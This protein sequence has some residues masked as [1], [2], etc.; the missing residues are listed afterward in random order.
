MS[1]IGKC[2]HCDRTFV[3]E[4]IYNGFNDTAYVYCD[5]CGCVA[6]ISAWSKLPAGVPI[7]FHERIGEEI[8]PFLQPCDCGGHFRASAGPRCPHCTTQLSPEIATGY[9]EA[10]APGAAMGWQWQ[11]SWSG[12]YCIIIEG[13][14]VKAQWITPS[15]PG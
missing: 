12:L 1:N 13:H 4:L 3:Y 15:G 6:F 8:E 5:S 14:S 9:L 10:N 11:G 2:E 7:R